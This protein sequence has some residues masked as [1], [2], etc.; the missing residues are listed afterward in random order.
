ML[1][2]NLWNMALHNFRKF[3]WISTNFTHSPLRHYRIYSRL[4]QVLRKVGSENPHCCARNVE[5]CFGIWRLFRAVFL[6]CRALATIIPGPRLIKRKEFTWPWSHKG[7]EP[8]FKA[9]RQRWWWIYQ[10]HR[11]R[12]RWWN[13]GFICECWNQRAVKAVDAHT[14]TKQAEKV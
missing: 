3:L 13:L 10:S 9:I 4:S 12:N 5:N 1:T 7:W 11:K 8:L 14:F 6:N 2:K